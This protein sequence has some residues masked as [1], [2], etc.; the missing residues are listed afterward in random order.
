[1][2]TGTFQ[3]VNPA[4]SHPKGKIT[5]PVTFGGELNYRTNKI[6]FDVVDIPLPYNGILGCP[7][8][9]KFM[10]ASHYAY[11][12]LKMPRP[13][14]VISI[15]SDE[16]DAIICMEKMYW[17]TVAAE[18]VVAAVPAKEDRGRKKG[19]KDA[20]KES[21]KHISSEYA[22]P[23]DDLP[24]SSHNKRSK[25]ADPQVKKVPTGLAG[26]DGNFTIST[27]FDDK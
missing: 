19:R 9:A 16:K 4:R 15:P 1:M 21:G 6:V 24:E 14:G 18:A 12:A 11:N 25:V 7:T 8:V 10:A 23:V 3:G 22:A 20:N 5:L 26:V 13:V 17:D 2:A 27:T